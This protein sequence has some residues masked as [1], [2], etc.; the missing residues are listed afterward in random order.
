VPWGKINALQSK[1][2]YGDTYDDTNDCKAI[3]FAGNFSSPYIDT[4]D[5]T[6][7]CSK[8]KV[9]IAALQLL[10]IIPAKVPT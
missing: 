1:Y 4:Y 7:R 8:D 9:I 2:T 5:S 6:G 10:Y 3:I